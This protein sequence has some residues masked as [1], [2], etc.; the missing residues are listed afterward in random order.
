LIVGRGILAGIKEA[1]MRKKYVVA[2]DGEHRA[3]LRRLIS[4]GSAPAREQAHAR[5]LLK[6]DAGETDEE[7]AESVEVGLAT[8]ARVRRRFAGGGLNAAVSRRPQ[9]PRPAKRKLDGAAEAHLVALACSKAPDG[10][11][12]WTMQLLADRMVELRHVGE[13]GVSDETVRRVLKKTRSG[14][15]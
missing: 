5:V 15:G 6:A 3:A 9:P 11:E 4:S 13:G 12:H 1:P 8:V 2:L 7:I 14:R 10:H